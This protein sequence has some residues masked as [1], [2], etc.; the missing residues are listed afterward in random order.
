M[1][2]HN[3]FTIEIYGLHIVYVSF[4]HEPLMAPSR[5]CDVGLGG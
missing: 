1:Y 4:C 5:Y 3:G 2:V